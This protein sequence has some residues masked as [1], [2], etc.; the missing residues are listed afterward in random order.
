LQ[1][2]RGKFHYRYHLY[3]IP[4]F[5]WQSYQRKISNFAQLLFQQVRYV[6]QCYRFGSAP[7]SEAVVFYSRLNQIEK[8][9]PYPHIWSKKQNPPGSASR[10]I[11]ER[12]RLATEGLSAS[13][14]IRSTSMRSGIRIRYKVNQI[15]ILMRNTVGMDPVYTVWYRTFMTKKSGT[16]LR[17]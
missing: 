8:P 9:D 7:F 6:T 10:E 5:E 1:C 15:R 12:W 4:F 11:R 17:K 2:F 16:C 14:Q 3:T 13:V